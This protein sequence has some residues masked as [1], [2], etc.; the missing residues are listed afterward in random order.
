MNPPEL[1]IR[2]PEGITFAYQLAGPITRCLAWTIDLLILVATFLGLSMAVGLSRAILPD[3][4]QAAMI[5]AWFILSL[6]YSIFFEWFWRGQTI[7]K[8][9]LR[10]RVMDADGLRLQFYQVLMRNLVRFADFLPGCY[11]VGGVACLLSRK[12]QRLGDLAAGTIVVHHRKTVEPD[13]EQ[14]LGTKFNSLRTQPHLC[15]RLRQRISPDE[16][17]LALQSLM[18]R[19]EFEPDERV[20]LFAEF[21]AHFKDRATFPAD[22][23]EA[24]P[25]E[26]FV[27]NVVDILFRT[28][29]TKAAA[30]KSSALPKLATA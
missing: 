29:E 20:R 3:I 21:A 8:K 26:Q 27:R 12:G 2:T 24:M 19:D 22:I 5:A 15:A 10:L 17:R 28:N 13:L 11:L 6:G 23:L 14:L 9:L 4:T 30:G 18:R 25:D 7:G 1:R 16:A